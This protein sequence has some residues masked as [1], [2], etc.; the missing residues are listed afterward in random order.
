MSMKISLIFSI[1]LSTT[2]LMT[3]NQLSQVQPHIVDSKV[4]SD[5]V[6]PAKDR[7]VLHGK[8]TEQT[9]QKSD[10]LNRAIFMANQDDTFYTVE[11]STFFDL[12]DLFDRDLVQIDDHAYSLPDAPE[13]IYFSA[14]LCL[15]SDQTIHSFT[16]CPK[17]ANYFYRLD[18][19]NGI[20]KAIF[21]RTIETNG[22]MYHFLEQH[23]NLIIVYQTSF[24]DSTEPC[25]NPIVANNLRPFF[26]YDLTKPSVPLTPYTM[27]PAEIKKGTL[28]KNKCLKEVS[29][30]I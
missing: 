3:C 1:F 19:K 18:T 5:E 15:S 21:A 13:T 8:V 6:I 2:F 22:V 24:S 16:T 28:I 9:F 20:G 11:G 30:S 12:S 7:I 27:P 25:W 29:G 23:E 10:D 14:I 17:I 26:T 4:V